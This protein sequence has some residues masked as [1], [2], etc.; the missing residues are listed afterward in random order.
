MNL[1]IIP[2]G[3][4]EDTGE[5]RWGLQFRPDESGDPALFAVDENS[6]DAISKLFYI[7]SGEA[8]IVPI[9]VAMH[10]M[11][12]RG[13]DP[14]QEGAPENMWSEAGGI[15]ICGS[16]HVSV[17]R[18]IA[19][20]SREFK[21]RLV[22][23]EKLT[24]KPPG[25][26]GHNIKVWGLQF[27]LCK[28]SMPTL[29]AVDIYTGSNV[30]DILWISPGSVGVIVDDVITKMISCGY[31]PWQKNA[32]VN[33]WGQYGGIRIMGTDSIDRMRDYAKWYTRS[34]DSPHPQ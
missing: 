2:P 25:P 26:H 11:R 30:C 21:P 17:T 12:E 3:H 31:D 27:G 5:K 20:K 22:W 24:C 28:N 32:P 4:P 19:P 29:S 18:D 1:K 8:G 13:Y 6:G 14:W 33:M 16:G 15:L 34:S 10:Y 9:S 23:P 7:S